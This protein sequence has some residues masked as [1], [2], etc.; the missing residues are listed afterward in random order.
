MKTKT[1]AAVVGGL[2]A[3]VVAAVVFL[4]RASTPKNAALAARQQAM[5]ML[6]QSIA[7]Q[8]PACK[9]LVL[10]NPF[11]K[12]SGML[13]ERAQFERAGIRGLRKG[14]GDLSVT[15]VFPE[16]RPEYFA[17]PQSVLIP[18]DSRTPLSF[19]IRPG[20]VAT[21]ADA[22]PQC[23][24]IVSLIGLPAGID[25]EKIWNPDDARTFALLLPDLRILG[26][27]EKAVEAYE[28]GKILVAV[29]EDSLQPGKHLIVT[30]N[31]VAEVLKR[32]PQALGY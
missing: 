8:K 2:A 1:T 29:V 17:D 15:V 6:G 13:D 26:P 5:E 30:R 25:Q 32:Q 31:N 28:Q 10:S 23:T 24:V 12:E 7:K 19:L 9:V 3:V 22:N 18:S 27:S 11:T 16:I 21:L 4:N 14:L 20:S